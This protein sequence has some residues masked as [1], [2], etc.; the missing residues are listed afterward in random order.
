VDGVPITYYETNKHPLN[1]VIAR[2]GATTFF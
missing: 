2:L 1:A